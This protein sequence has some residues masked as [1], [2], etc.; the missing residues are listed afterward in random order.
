MT[1][2][3]EGMDAGAM[4][5][6]ARAASIKLETYNPE[7]LV[8]EVQAFLLRKGL[9]PDAT[10]RGGMAGGAAGQLLRAFNILPAMDHTTIDRHNAL[11]PESR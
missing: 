1:T 2:E 5:R 6:R 4:L 7:Q 3:P 8:V 10:G 9:H 11:D